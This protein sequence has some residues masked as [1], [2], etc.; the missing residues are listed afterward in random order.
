MLPK[1]SPIIS[2]PVIW[3]IVERFGDFHHYRTL[4]ALFKQFAAI[5][6]HAQYGIRRIKRVC[7]APSRAVQSRL[8]VPAL[9]SGVNI[10]HFEIIFYVFTCYSVPYIS[11]RKIALSHKAMTR[12]QFSP[13]RSREIGRASCRERV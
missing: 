10:A 11:H 2:R 8:T 1:F 5:F 4:Y 6:V 13:R 12:E 7:R 9:F 3:L